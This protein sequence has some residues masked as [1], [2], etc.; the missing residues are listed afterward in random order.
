LQP[1]VV[2]DN[3]QEFVLSN[4]IL[5]VQPFHRLCK[6]ICTFNHFYFRQFS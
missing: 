6:C 2:R 5:Q 4:V 1:F 3:I